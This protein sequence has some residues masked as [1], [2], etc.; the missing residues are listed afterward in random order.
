[1]KRLWI[2][3]LLLALLALTACARQAAPTSEATGECAEPAEGNE[4]LTN[5]EAGYCLVY[6]D[7]Y[8]AEG[9]FYA[10]MIDPAPGRQ[11]QEPQLPFAEIQ[12]TTADGRSATQ[13]ADEMVAGMPDFPIERST[14][15]L[16]GEEAIVLDRLP[17]QEL[18]R[19]I[20]IVHDDLLYRFTFVPADPAADLYT[21]MEQLYATVTSSFNF[22]SEGAQAPIESIPGPDMGPPADE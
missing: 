9:P 11:G 2:V 17:G 10:T 16:D 22:L 7:S 5:E 21:E 1:M 3:T 19:Q 4:L 15:T 8:V 12:V 18:N 13:V 20:L 14:L 6:P